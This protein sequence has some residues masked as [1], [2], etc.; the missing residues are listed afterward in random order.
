MR[1]RRLLLWPAAVVVGLAAESV[2]FDWSEPRDWLPDLVVGWTLIACGLIAWSKRPASRSGGLMTAAGFAWFAANFTSTDLAALNWLGEQA[3]Y[4]HRGPLVHLV[5]AYPG[6]R[7]T[8]TVDRV[9]VA[10]GY[11]AAVLPA[12]WG[13]E[14]VAC[15]LAAAMTAVAGRGYL[16]AVGLRRRTRLA[17]LQA[18]GFLAAVFA[19]TAAVRLAFPTQE[20]T[21]ATLV[22]YEAAI[23]GLALVSLAGLIAEPWA[24]E[25]ITDLV[26]DLGETRAGTL[27][28]G[29]AA[30]LGDPT[31]EVGYWVGGR[32]VDAGGRPLALPAEDGERGI[33]PVERD[34]EP[35][36]LLVHDPAVLADPGLSDALARAARLAASNA[37]LQAEV[38]AQL[39]EIAASRRRLVHAGDEERRR[40]ERRLRQS[41]ERRLVELAPTLRS[42]HDQ[43]PGDELVLLAER[44]LA[45][46][47]EDVRLL[48]QGLHP[49]GLE[50][51]GLGSALASLAASSPVPVE[52]RVEG[53]TVPDEVGTAA[54]FVC[55]EALANVIKSAGASR[56]LISVRE[57]GQHLEALIED[58]GVGGADPAR[59][60]GLRGLS[61]RVEALGGTLVID[62]PCGQGTRVV[63]SLPVG[64]VER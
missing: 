62:S 54:Y 29:L 24:R 59:G 39:D 1:A 48:A 28:D 35:I 7:A 52:L 15:L 47:L 12:I 55:S 32:Y 18:T 30:A 4:L 50:E 37:R 31:L 36:A 10:G 33:T 45:R 20:V 16:G 61:D 53:V 46:T 38:R 22:V 43:N 9:A 26:V 41:V 21:D 57:D 6:G 2:A 23:C 60:S 27:R 19:G 8:S 51:G 49:H 56:A 14:V 64:P 13:S 25:K 3:L 11:V 34:G 5:L 44:Q 58:D 40:L 42:A 17:A 63:A